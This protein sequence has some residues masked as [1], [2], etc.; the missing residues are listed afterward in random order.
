MIKWKFCKW[1][2]QITEITS[3]GGR[4][5]D[6]RFIKHLKELTRIKAEEAL[7]IIKW[8]RGQIPNWLYQNRL[9]KLESE[10]D[11]LEN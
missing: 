6:K 1:N 5:S 7:D 11:S 2:G 3:D 10:N 8:R 9:N 4:E